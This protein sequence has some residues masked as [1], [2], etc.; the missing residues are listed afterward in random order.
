MRF[1]Q[2]LSGEDSY[3]RLE[4]LSRQLGAYGDLFEILESYLRDVNSLPPSLSEPS[5][6]LIQAAIDP[7]PEQ[8]HNECLAECGLVQCN[9]CFPGNN[10]IC[11][12]CWITCDIGCSIGCG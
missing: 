4:S 7:L 1:A 11:A 5:N 8:C 9:D 2:G 3:T 6:N 10:P 12:I